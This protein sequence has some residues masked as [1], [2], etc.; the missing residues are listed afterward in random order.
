MTNQT[1][2]NKIYLGAKGK[3]SL[4]DVSLPDN[5]NQEMIIFIHGY[6]GFKDWGCWNL[7]QDFFNQHQ[8]GFVKYNVSHNGCTI[9]NSTEFVDLDS[10][11]NNNYSN[12]LD[13]LNSII[14]IVKANYPSVVKIH[15]IGH[16]RGGG[17]AL[18]QSQNN[19]ID[20]ICSWAG[21]CDIGKR[22]PKGDELEVWKKNQIRY[23]LNRRTGQQMPLHYSQ[24]EDYM[25]N[26]ERLHIESHCRNSDTPTLL[27]H[28]DKD[29]SISINEGKSMA[30]W[31]NTELRI[32]QNTGHTFDS[33]HPWTENQ[34]PYPLLEICEITLDFLNAS[35]HTI[36][37]KYHLMSSLIQLA[38]S[39]QELHEREFHFL[40]TIANQLGMNVDEFKLLFDKYIS[41]QPPALENDRIVQFY[42]L[43]LLMNVDGE[44]KENEVRLIKEI[45]IRMGLNQEATEEIIRMLRENP[46][47]PIPP[48]TLISLFKT[49]HN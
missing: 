16:S 32:I 49:H 7:V 6:M 23:V 22:F 46:E 8:F 31:L 11:S 35:G 20:K 9:E 39:D 48:S 24:F 17:I 37:E 36:S 38:D 30:D 41:F 19:D 12:E 10:F 40:L 4:Y 27:I 25:Q 14:T 44:S 13:D 5:W 15:L 34:L 33:S 3:K 18:L 42:R 21:I 2:K 45:G 43:A 47:T 28:G 26:R 1:V 29:E